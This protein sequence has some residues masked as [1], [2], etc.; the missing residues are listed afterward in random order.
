MPH[1]CFHSA[2]AFAPPGGSRRGVVWDVETA[3]T[4]PHCRAGQTLQGGAIPPDD[5]AYVRGW[6]SSVQ[7]LGTPAVVFHDG[8]SPA[9]IS[10]LQSRERRRNG[11]RLTHAGIG[12]GTSP[13]GPCLGACVV[14]AHVP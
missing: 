5:L 7:H 1:A 8:L 13:P 11:G 4:A 12:A 2:T 10:E 6:H 9:F 14:W 3:L